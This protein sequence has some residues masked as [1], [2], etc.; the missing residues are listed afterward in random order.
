[1]QLQSL[2]YSQ[3]PAMSSWKGPMTSSQTR[4]RISLHSGVVS[5][6]PSL[7]TLETLTPLLR[8]EYHEIIKILLSRAS[9]IQ[10]VYDIRTDVLCCEIGRPP[11][12]YLVMITPTAT[13]S[14]RSIST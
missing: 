14:N 2:V 5:F 7:K 9:P 12:S 4:S 6:T 11:K 1:M 8:S 10:C 13:I 3:I